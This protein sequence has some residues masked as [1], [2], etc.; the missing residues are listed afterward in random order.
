MPLT[1]KIRELSPSKIFDRKLVQHM[2]VSVIISNT[3]V[4]KNLKIHFSK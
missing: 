1:S 2:L 4:E 3:G